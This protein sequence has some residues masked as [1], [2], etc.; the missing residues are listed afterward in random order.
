M[1]L[2]HVDWKERE[3]YKQTCKN[4]SE[5]DEESVGEAEKKGKKVDVSK[6]V[7]WGKLRH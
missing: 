7:K 1:T 4:R 5:S 6:G 3:G 2:K